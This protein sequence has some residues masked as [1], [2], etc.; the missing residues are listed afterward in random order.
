MSL[1]V[2]PELAEKAAAGTVTRDE[3]LRCVAT[4]L[5]YA[6]ARVEDL[7]DHIRNGAS[8]A[9]DNSVPQT[10]QEWGQL[11]RFFSSTPIRTAAEQHFGVKLAFQNCC[12]A[13]AFHPVTGLDELAA[14][15]SMEAQLRNQDPAL[16]NC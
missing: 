3:F 6:Y 9:Y 16:L 8:E 14:F 15:S 5:P 2:S 10:D 4:S 7:A 1:T 11:L 12:N 13:G